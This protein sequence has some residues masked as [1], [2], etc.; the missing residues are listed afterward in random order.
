MYR[1]LN[2]EHLSASNREWRQAHPERVRIFAMTRYARRK[3]AEGS[4]TTQQWEELKL[5]YEYTCLCCRKQE[6]EIFSDCSE[7]GKNEIK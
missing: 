2:A 4:V 6:P 5:A 3:G 7:S 1:Q